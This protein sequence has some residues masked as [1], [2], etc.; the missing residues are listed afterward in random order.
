MTCEEILKQLNPEQGEAVSTTEGPVLVL[1]GAGTGK[2]R[3]ITFRIAYMLSKGIPPES[4]LGMTFTNKAAKEMRERLAQLVSPALAEKVTL[5]TFHSFCGKLLRREIKRLGYMPNFTIADE[6]DQMGIFKQAA[7]EIGCS[8]DFPYS[9]AFA[10]M[11]RWKNQL[12]MPRDARDRAENQFEVTSGVIYEKYQELLELQNLVD[13]DDMLMLTWRIF[14][15]FPEVL[16]K[17]RERFRY[18]MVDEYQDTNGAQFAL[19]KML[20][21]EICN[22]CVVGDDDQSIYS[23]RGADVGNILDFPELFPGTKVVKL[24]QNYRSCGAILNAANAVIARGGDARRHTKTL[25]SALGDG[26]TPEIISLPDGENEADFI[27][28]VIEQ[29]RRE[30]DCTYNDF[31]ILYRSNQLSRQ[32]EQTL[33]AAQIPYRMVGGQQFFQRREIKDALA[34]MRVMSNPCD[35]Q[36]LLR[37]LSSPPRGIGAKAIAEMKKFRS[38]GRGSMFDALSSED[39]RKSLSKPAAKGAEEL[40]TVFRRYKTLFEQ[41]GGLSGKCAQFLRDAGYVGGLQ[42]VYKDIADAVKRRDNVDEFISAIAQ[43]ESKREEPTSL[44]DYLEACSLLEESEKEDEKETVTDAVTLTTIHAAKGLEYPVVFVIAMENGIF[45]HERAL[46]EGGADEEKRLFY[47]AV[48]RAKEE[49]YLSRTRMRLVRGVMRPAQPSP[50]LAMIDGEFANTVE[51]EDILKTADKKTMSDK[52]AELYAL[53][54][55]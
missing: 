24:E 12:V 10:L 55:S 34:Y 1:A 46:E 50:F 18:L 39:F 22:L 48:T 4:I 47:V 19:V 52:F 36:S 29:R 11:N 32:L 21:G 13:F 14:K 3:V 44:S 33:R 8:G 20:A 54:D 43:F 23:W 42:K 7:G 53:L 2:T 16:D 5:G 51:P 6:S 35:D 45:P 49:L 38:E 41:P 40:M 37:V 30:R 31:A 25:W 27:S 26:K 28:R 17:Y 15:E 9:A